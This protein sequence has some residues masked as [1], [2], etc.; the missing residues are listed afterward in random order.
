MEGIEGE[1][2]TWCSCGS[3][4]AVGMARGRLALS[5]GQGTEAQEA[6]CHGPERSLNLALSL[7]GCKLAGRQYK[8][9]GN[10]EDPESHRA[11]GSLDACPWLLWRWG[12]MSLT[13]SNV[14]MACFIQQAPLSHTRGNWG[15]EKEERWSEVTQKVSARSPHSN[16]FL[17]L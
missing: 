14:T 17:V 1:L 7:R 12:G 8:Q 13:L 16:L 4:R 2:R 9:R 11:L 15:S 5:L 10:F 3:V 6:D